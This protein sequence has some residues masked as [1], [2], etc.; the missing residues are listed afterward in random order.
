MKRNALLL[1][2]LMSLITTFCLSSCEKSTG[3][4]DGFF[5]AES[6]LDNLM[7]SVFGRY[8]SGESGNS[9]AEI[10]LNATLTDE[11]LEGPMK[12]EL[13]SLLNG[14]N[15]EFKHSLKLDY[16]DRTVDLTLFNSNSG[17]YISSPAILEKDVNVTELFSL[18]EAD[19]YIK[20]IYSSDF[21][22]NV[23]DQASANSFTDSFESVPV[24]GKEQSLSVITLTLDNTELNKYTEADGIDSSLRYSRGIH[25]GTVYFEEIVI[26]KFRLIYIFSDGN[27]DKATLDI[28]YESAKLLEAEYS[29]EGHLTDPTRRIYA[30][31]PNG[32]LKLS[33]ES[34]TGTN[35]KN[36]F[37]V[38]LDI[39][40]KHT[41]SYFGNV[42]VEKNFDEGFTLYVDGR[43]DTDSL[44]IDISGEG[45]YISNTSEKL[46]FPERFDAYLPDED[47]SDIFVGELA[48]KFSLFY[49]LIK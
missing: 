2:L 45:K 4:K 28:S 42:S 11:K 35:T 10:S 23:K 7:N 21:L 24:D 32:E 47:P 40:G 14:S 49:D 13:N 9:T 15:V 36:S 46:A 30:K 34:L 6:S 26:G 37:K 25:Q 17:S 41:F 16:I 18:G 5:S 12:V 19:K 38:T 43:L 33:V 8:Y 22:N 1:I 27:K 3:G 44:S 20:L 31:T 39:V 48:D 29:L